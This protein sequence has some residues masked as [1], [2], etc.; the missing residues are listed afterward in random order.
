MRTT[1]NLT[2]VRISRDWYRLDTA[3]GTY[4][5]YSQVEVLGKHDTAVLNCFE[6]H[7]GAASFL[8]SSGRAAATASAENRITCALALYQEH[9]HLRDKMHT[10]A[11]AFNG[12]N[13]MMRLESE[14]VIEESDN[15]RSALA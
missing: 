14:A 6:K 12:W 4:F 13:L 5:G 9:P 7:G 3:R 8:L 15:Q 2:P 11:Q 1:K 10:I